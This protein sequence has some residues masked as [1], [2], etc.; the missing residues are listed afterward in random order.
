MGY[1]CTRGP[2]CIICVMSVISWIGVHYVVEL[3]CKNIK[4]V[5]PIDVESPGV[6]QRHQEAQGS[7]YID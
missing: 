7:F 4:L 5:V 2:M 1:N 3:I 6:K